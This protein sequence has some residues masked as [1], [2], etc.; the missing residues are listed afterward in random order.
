MTT[1]EIVLRRPEDVTA[2]DVE[3]LSTVDAPPE[4]GSMIVG[5]EHDRWVV[6]LIE[7]PVDAANQA[8]LICLPVADVP[9][10]DPG[11]R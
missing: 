7:A 3:F 5:A 8:R 6:I 10:A 9:G 1:F 4:V 2:E 11:I